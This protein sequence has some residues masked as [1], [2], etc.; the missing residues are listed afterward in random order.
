MP[1][2]ER[3]AHER[4]LAPQEVQAALWGWVEA[5]LPEARRLG[6]REVRHYPQVLVPDDALSIVA[7][8]VELLTSLAA[9]REVYGSGLLGLLHVVVHRLASA[10]ARQLRPRREVPCGVG[11]GADESDVEP[12]RRDRLS[13]LLDGERRSSLTEELRAAA[14]LDALDRMFPRVRAALPAAVAS[15]EVTIRA[16]QPSPREATVSDPEPTPAGRARE[17]KRLERERAAAFSWLNGQARGFERDVLTTLARGADAACRR[18]WRA[19]LLEHLQSD[20]PADSGSDVHAQPAE[21]DR[22]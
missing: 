16:E 18:G 6:M 12:A 9:R 17:R 22:T 1:I 11:R 19:A 5:H 3:Y 14:A 20:K 4:P 21:P 8:A 7:E 2:D 15:G 13:R 10:R